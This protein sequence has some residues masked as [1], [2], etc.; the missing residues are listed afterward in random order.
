VPC[1]SSTRSLPVDI[2]GGEVTLLHLERQGVRWVG[3]GRLSLDIAEGGQSEKAMSR[4]G[5]KLK[6]VRKPEAG[7]Q[8]GRDHERQYWWVVAADAA[9]RVDGNCGH[10]HV[11]VTEAYACLGHRPGEHVF[12]VHA[13]EERKW[14]TR[15]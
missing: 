6:T 4:A 11:L 2:L 1:R 9:S 13:D 3:G 14:R 8:K 5:R 10:K 15:R 7:R 12:L